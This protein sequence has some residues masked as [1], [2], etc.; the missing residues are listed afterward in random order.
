LSCSSFV[1]VIAANAVKE[2]FPPFLNGGR[3]IT[4]ALPLLQNPKYYSPY[5]HLGKV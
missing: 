1:T 2:G 3:T 5:T 4:P